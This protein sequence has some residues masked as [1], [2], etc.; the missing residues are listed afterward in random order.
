MGTTK[1]V[2]QEQNLET[3]IAEHVERAYIAGMLDTSST[4]MAHVTKAP[5]YNLDY[6]IE[7]E[8]ALSRT[9]ANAVFII[10]DFCTVNGIKSNVNED[11]GRYTFSIERVPDILRFL[12]LVGPFLQT[13]REDAEVLQ[14][15]ILPAMQDGKHLSDKNSFTELV[16]D[17]EYLREIVPRTANSKYTAEFFRQK[18]NL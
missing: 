7:P 8:I 10:D 18:W 15:R 1:E 17:I 16:K 3:Q 9:D 12:D 5:D 13:R 11:D 2:E 6:T 14:E 4:I